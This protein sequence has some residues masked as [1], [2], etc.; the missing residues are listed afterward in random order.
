M[1]ILS[2]HSSKRKQQ[3]F[4]LF[5]L[6]FFV[7]GG[8]KMNIELKFIFGLLF[9]NKRSATVRCGSYGDMGVLV[10]VLL[11]TVPTTS[12]TG[13]GSGVLL[14]PKTFIYCPIFGWWKL[15]VEKMERIKY[16]IFL[17]TSI[18]NGKKNIFF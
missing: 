9:S 10:A 18:S 6:R 8:P 1:N 3:L 7:K 15:F 14:L 11:I 12:M 4:K 13:G 2:G 17:H 5:A 16:Q